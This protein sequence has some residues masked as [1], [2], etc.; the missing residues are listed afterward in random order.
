MG[1]YEQIIHTLNFVAPAWGVAL[2]CVLMAR[3]GAR[4]GL[5][6]SRGGLFKQLVVSAVLGMVALGA[7]LFLW[8]VDGKMTS[9]AALV[10]VCGTTQWLMCRGWRRV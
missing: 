8:D 7:G 5:R 10:V 2:F 6:A 1:P 3:F 9:Y 4:A